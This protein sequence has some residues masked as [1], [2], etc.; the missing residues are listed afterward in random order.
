MEGTSPRSNGLY[1][2]SFAPAWTTCR[3]DKSFP[4]LV[5]Q[6]IGMCLVDGSFC[7]SVMIISARSFSNPRSSKMRSS[8][9]LVASVM[10]SGFACRNYIIA[11]P[12]RFACK[13][14]RFQNAKRRVGQCRP[15]YDIIN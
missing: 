13:V 11:A 12:Q 4:Y 15:I 1:K 3:T 5:S 9:A 10:S 7:K 14:A 6:R 8:P 2:I